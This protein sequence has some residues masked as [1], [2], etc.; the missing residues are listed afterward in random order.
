MLVDCIG[1]IVPQAELTGRWT[2]EVH[3]NLFLINPNEVPVP[4]G[5]LQ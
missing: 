3:P 4:C 5:L 1:G 2:L